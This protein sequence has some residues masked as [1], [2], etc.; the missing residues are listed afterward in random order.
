LVLLAEIRWQFRQRGWTGVVDHLG[1]TLKD[2]LLFALLVWFVY[3]AFWVVY[4]VPRE[5]MIESE[6]IEHP[7][8]A[9]PKP[10]LGWDA[11]TPRVLV[12][13]SSNVESTGFKRSP[14]NDSAP[15]W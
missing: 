13:P 12:K 2:G 1:K 5:I 4:K 7:V 8:I 3:F 9:Q 10:P 14:L 15:L 11:K 6:N